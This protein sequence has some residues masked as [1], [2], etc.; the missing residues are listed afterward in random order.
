MLGRNPGLLHSLE[1]WPGAAPAQSRRYLSLICTKAPQGP[2]T[3]IQKLGGI[4]WERRHTSSMSQSERSASV[5]KAGL[6]EDKGKLAAC[7][8]AGP[9]IREE[10]I[11]VGQDSSPWRSP[12]SRRTVRPFVDVLQAVACC[13]GPSRLPAG[14]SSR[15]ASVAHGCY[16]IL[17]QRTAARWIPELQTHPFNSRPGTSLNQRDH[18]VAGKAP[19]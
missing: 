8:L 10:G 12:S 16:H 13:Q 2:G 15:E 4:C 18:Q 11:P 6:T 14:D 17:A 19:I 7:T 3:R 1:P 9:S 5:C